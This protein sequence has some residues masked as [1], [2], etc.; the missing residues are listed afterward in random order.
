MA[1]TIEV[2][3]GGDEASTS[4]GITASFT[5]AENST[6]AVEGA[7]GA[8]LGLI[9][10]SDPDADDTH[11]VE[12]DNDRFQVIDHAGAKWLTLKS[13]VSL[14]FEENETVTLTVTVTDSGDP[15]ESA[16]Q[17][18]TIMV[19][20]VN[21]APSIEVAD[22]ETPDGM[23]ASSTVDENVEGA[24]L[25]AITLSDPDAG[26][27]HTLSTSDDRF[28]TKQD[29]EGGWWLALADGVS[30]NF[31]DEASHHGAEVTVTVTVTDDGDPAMSASTDVT[32]TV[33]D[34]NEAP[35]AS[36][37]KPPDLYAEAGDDVSWTVDLTHLLVDP[38]PGDSNLTYS[39]ATPAGLLGE[40]ESLSISVSHSEDGD[41]NRKIT[42]TITAP[43]KL[44]AGLFGS[45]DVHISAADD[46]GAESSIVQ[47]VVVDDG[48]DIITSIDLYH[49]NEDGT[50]GAQNFS[51]AVD[52]DENHAGEVTLGRVKVEDLDS[53][54]HLNG[55]HIVT[56]TGSQARNFDIKDGVLVKRAGVSLDRE[57]DDGTSL[58]VTIQAVDPGGGKYPPG[59]P[60]AGQYRE[61]KTQNVIVDINDQ[62]DDPIANVDPDKAGWWVTVSDDLDEETV[63][64][65]DWL[66]FK[67]QTEGVNAAFTDEDLNG[68]DPTYKIQVV[69][70]PQFL[71]I[72]KEGMIEN[73][74]KMLPPE[75]GGV[76]DVRV[77]AEYKDK[78]PVHFDFQLSVAYSGDNDDTKLRKSSD[79]DYLEGSGAGVVVAT[80]TVDDDNSHLTGHP[81]APLAPRIA[82]VVNADKPEAP[83]DPNGDLSNDLN[84]SDGATG[85]GAAFTIDR[86]GTSNTYEIKTADDPKTRTSTGTPFD[87]TTLLDHENVDDLTI[88]VAIR[89][90]VGELDD[91]T[92]TINIGVDDRNEKPEY[93]GDGD[94]SDFSPDKVFPVEQFIEDE[95]G[96]EKAD[97]G[98]VALW[99]KLYDVW[100]DEDEGSGND[101]DDLT[102]GVT[103][104]AAYQSWITVKYGPAEWEEIKEGANERDDNGTGDDVAWRGGDGAGARNPAWAENPD[105][106]PDGDDW[107]VVIEIDRSKANNRQSD[108]TIDQEGS[109]RPPLGG[110]SFTLTATDDDGARGT[111]PIY[112]SVTD[113]N[114]DADMSK[115]VTITGTPREGRPLVANFD[116]TQDPD[117]AGKASAQLVIYTWSALA[118]GADDNDAGTPRQEGTSN[119]YVPTQQDVGMKIKVSVTYYEMVPTPASEA[120]TMG[121]RGA[122]QLSSEPQDGGFK[123]TGS[124]TVS[125]SQNPGTVHIHVRTNDDNNG[126]TADVALSDRD[127][128]PTGDDA[129]E[130]R[131]EKSINGQ[132]GWEPA[133]PGDVVS[134]QN[135]ALADGNGKGEYYRLV[136]T[137]TDNGDFQERHVSDNIKVGELANAP[138]TDALALVSTGQT[139]VGGILQVNGVP[140]TGSSVQW[141]QG[142]DGNR[143]GSLGDPEDYWVDIPD[144]T[145]ASLTITADHAGATLRAVVTSTD[146][147]GNVADIDVVTGTATI[148]AR[149]NTAP[150]MV[151]H[152][153]EDAQVNDEGDFTRVH[154]KDID[155]SA[156]FEDLNGDR[157][158]YSVTRFTPNVDDRSIAENGD[159]RDTEWSGGNADHVV[160]F[161]VNGSTGELLYV[162]DKKNE[163][164]DD[165]GDDGGNMVSFTITASDNRPG[166]APATAMVSVRLN[167]KPSDI[168]LSDPS[169][170]T[171]V[172]SASAYGTFEAATET[173]PAEITFRERDAE[174]DTDPP[175]TGNEVLA[176]INVQDENSPMHGY[177]KHDVQV[178][179]DAKDRFEI[180]NEDPGNARYPDANE[181]TWQLRLKKG[182]T[183]DFDSE[184][185]RNMFKIELTI[186][187][188]D[189][190][191][192][193]VKE[194][195][196][197]TVTNDRDDDADEPGDEDTVPGLS[198]DETGDDNDK[199]DDDGS[200]TDTDT[201]G[202]WTPPPPGMSVGGLIEDFMDTMDGAGQDVFDDF[203]LVIDDGLDIA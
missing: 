145:G 151:K 103:V 148:G 193:E 187:A 165:G 190:G 42:G 108:V 104:P 19:T 90:G 166:S 27:M 133:N 49:L 75:D 113:E 173:T 125:N 22:G 185:V 121:Q 47:T 162:T 161:K 142:V 39:I 129:P 200:G 2:A 202:G 158:T 147:D 13:G 143:N 180:T 11:T 1:P 198:D 100:E 85:Y 153:T 102:Y 71:E 150:S 66:T 118:A 37:T 137:Y 55:Q 24:I 107:V 170:A 57:G 79:S 33:N 78:S 123:T 5:V 80:F 105:Q 35:A 26:Q 76:Y 152:H 182:A 54:D 44:A 61:V 127:G 48:N 77:T 163:H 51:Y 87:D 174:R 45:F 134:D 139:Q 89:D 4:G 189:G 191:G 176:V 38:D 92:L 114:L 70:G 119:R 69:N 95:D 183:F 132:G 106:E 28:V 157:L 97:Q 171:L 46:E 109:G 140:P 136:V 81:F 20:D 128:E 178:T 74:E 6:D 179:G 59:H 60:K 63:D 199:T 115:A 50:D 30:L 17:E 135:L 126:L 62:D 186:T 111:Q 156:L 175:A 120:G 96:V 188:T 131:W 41:G 146:E 25:G 68:G 94:P 177:G 154:V 83:G 149:P 196:T 36:D 29:A 23:A 7:A 9:T 169:D 116:E 82:S 159:P 3:G 53:P 16:S 31:E 203:M 86:V 124:S 172:P 141:Q 72:D 56:V 65:G 122:L 84:L 138:G 144:A 155:L 8:V 34:V 58:T 197:I 73:K 88:T 164:D 201:D 10:L 192:K 43:K 91:D 130:Y 110:G 184:A 67:L 98:K 181:S 21:E 40:G 99:I 101:D 168:E 32:I 64:T 15:A 195:L 167:V 112:V 93:A 117:L 18:V 52:V 194:K 14:D 160:S 12:V